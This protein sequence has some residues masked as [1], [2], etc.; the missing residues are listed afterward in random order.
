MD[1]SSGEHQRLY[2]K[3]KI[4]HIYGKLGE[5]GLSGIISRSANR[6]EYGS[7]QPE[8]V[9]NIAKYIRTINEDWNEGKVDSWFKPKE[10]KAEIRS[11]QNVYFLGFGFDHQNLSLLGFD[12]H[13]HKAISTKPWPNAKGTIKGFNKDEYAIKSLYDL[14]PKFESFDGTVLQFLKTHPVV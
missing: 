2:E 4:Y 14:I 7:Y 11:A 13:S 6:K 9:I 12:G 3:I 10:I 5:Y 8:D 1:L